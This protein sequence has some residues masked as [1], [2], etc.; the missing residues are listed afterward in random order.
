MNID[1][2]VMKDYI[3]G[4]INNLNVSFAPHERK[5]VAYVVA[6]NI[7]IDLLEFLQDYVD[8][9][10]LLIRIINNQEGIR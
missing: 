9:N 2:D 6:N 4:K 5:L 3:V 10:N 7:Y 8:A 1:T